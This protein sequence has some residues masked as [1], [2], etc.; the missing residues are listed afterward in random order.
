[1]KNNKDFLRIGVFYDGTFFVKAQNFLYGQGYG[2]LSFQELHKLFENFSRTKEQGFSLSKVV[3]SAWFQ[4]L[5]KSSQATEDNLRLDRKRQH[6]LLHAGIEPRNIPMSETQG[7]KGIDVYMAVETLQI[8]LDEKIDLAILVTGDGDFV[9]LVR[10]LMKN[11][12]RVMIAYF[13]FQEGDK[14]LSFANERL[15]NSAN[16]QLCINKLEYDKEFK[17]EFKSIFRKPEDFER[18]K[19]NKS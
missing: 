13:E 19:K 15:L 2:W 7:E 14:K 1:M 8:G 4:G 5:Y 10:A 17:A 18:Q 9:P 12:V 11:G 6:D 16:Y 3:Y